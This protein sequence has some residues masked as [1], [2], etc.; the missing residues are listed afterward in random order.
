MEG[1]INLIFYIATGTSVL[2]CIFIWLGEIKLS[3]NCFI[4]YYY[5]PSAVV[6]AALGAAAPYLYLN[7]LLNIS[8]GEASLLYIFL[9]V[10]HIAF[11]IGSNIT[12]L[13]LFRDKDA[14]N[15]TFFWCLS[16][17]ALF[18]VPF[19]IVKLFGI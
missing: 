18:V 8:I 11:L 17:S 9:I 14:F 15:S 19:W 13:L 3:G 2:A 5:I 10:L 7:G 6:N 12:F 1:I 16:M 4:W